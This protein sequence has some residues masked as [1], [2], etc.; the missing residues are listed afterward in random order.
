MGICSPFETSLKQQTFLPHWKKTPNRVLCLAVGYEQAIICL[1]K[2]YEVF[3]FFFRIQRALCSLSIS[4]ITGI[5]KCQKILYLVE[6]VKIT[7]RSGN[8]LRI[9]VATLGRIVPYRIKLGEDNSGRSRLKE[10]CW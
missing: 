6:A 2:K 5:L 3:F 8:F 7:D 9:N 4:L 10:R 1:P